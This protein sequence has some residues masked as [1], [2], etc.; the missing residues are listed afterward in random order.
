MELILPVFVRPKDSREEEVT[1]DDC[2]IKPMIFFT[3]DNAEKLEEDGKSVTLF[4][5]GNCS[6]K[7][8]L[9]I[10]VFLAKR[11]EA[12]KQDILF[13]HQVLNGEV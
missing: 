7:C 1:L 6:F 9:P 13:A 5:S 4:D 8:N 10:D 11:K 2:I 12:L 3:I